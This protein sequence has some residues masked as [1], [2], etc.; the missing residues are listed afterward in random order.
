MKRIGSTNAECVCSNG[1]SAFIKKGVRGKEEAKQL[2][3]RHHTS[4][5]AVV[6]RQ[7]AGRHRIYGHCWGY[8]LRFGTSGVLAAG[9]Y[10]LQS[11]ASLKKYWPAARKTPLHTRRTFSCPAAE[12]VIKALG[13]DLKRDTNQSLALQIT[14]REIIRIGT[15]QLNS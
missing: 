6:P 1:N 4:T 3:Q 13:W 5:N 11:G 10:P 14:A 9:I 2:L 7:W 12:A 15:G 8:V